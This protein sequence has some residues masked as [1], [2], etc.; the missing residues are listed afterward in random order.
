[1]KMITSLGLDG[2]VIADLYE[3]VQHELSAGADLYLGLITFPAGIGQVVGGQNDENLEYQL[4]AEKDGE[5]FNSKL[6]DYLNSGWLPHMGPTPWRGYFIQWVCRERAMAVGVLAM[7]ARRPMHVNVV[8]DEPVL[9][10]VER[11]QRLF[12]FP[13]DVPS[14]LLG[15]E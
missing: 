9:H 4:I 15:Q 7:S 6:E 3:R 12:L 1:M 8:A 5:A 13:S 10:V 11:V 2:G 14:I